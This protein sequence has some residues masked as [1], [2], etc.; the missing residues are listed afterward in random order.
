MVYLVLIIIYIR[1]NY[2]GLS[3]LAV[4]DLATHILD[5][6]LVYGLVGH[7]VILFLEDVEL[8]SVLLLILGLHYICRLELLISR[9]EKH[10]ECLIV[11]EALPSLSLDTLLVLRRKAPCVGAF[12]FSGLDGAHGLRAVFLVGQVKSLLVDGFIHFFD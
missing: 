2:H 9:L 3:K 12:L 4:T 5:V 8:A 7:L 6:L 11:F 10:G 1:L